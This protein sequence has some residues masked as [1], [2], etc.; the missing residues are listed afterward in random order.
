M[1]DVDM[2]IEGDV[3]TVCRVCAHDHTKTMIAMHGHVRQSTM[4]GG[5]GRDVVVVGAGK[6]SALDNDDVNT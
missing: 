6:A 5:I 4:V 3:V 1:N 2:V